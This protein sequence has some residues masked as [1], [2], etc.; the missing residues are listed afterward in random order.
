LSE[1]T[2][3][4][5]TTQYLDEADR[6]ADTIAVVDHGLVIAEGTSDELKDR[7][8]GER[9][10][11]TLE[12]RSDADAAIQALISMA[13]DRPSCDG[14]IVVMSVRRRHGTIVEAVRRLGDAGV[15]VEDLALRRPTLDDVFL[16]L[17]GHAA[18]ERAAQAEEAAA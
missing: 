4:L 6:L 3:V 5:L 14:N 8:G 7:V 11:V 17:T 12:D 18:E 2:T 16:T 10:E 9:L 15:E 13:A 1:G